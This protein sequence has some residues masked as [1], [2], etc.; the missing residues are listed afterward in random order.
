MGA[1]GFRLPGI[2]EW[3]LAA[4]WKKD[5]LNTVSGYSDPSY[6]KGDSAS[7]ATGDY[8]NHLASREIAWYRDNNGAATQESGLKRANDLGL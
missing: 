7:E 8:E 3:E 1:N 4:R 5:S 6:T 2:F